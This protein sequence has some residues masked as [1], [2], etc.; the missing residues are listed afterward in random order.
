[1]EQRTDRLAGR[2]RQLMDNY[3][4]LEYFG[5][6][7]SPVMRLREL[8]KSFCEADHAFSGRFLS[9]LNRIVR[10]SEL[11]GM[12]ELGSFEVREFGE[13][14]RTRESVEKFLNNGTQEEIEG[15]TKVYMKEMPEDNF[16]S[17]L[18]RQ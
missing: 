18:M 5:G 7:G 12:Q 17:L 6:I 1:M 11:E 9:R 16:K 14:E 3:G 10:V 4:D 13:F 2:I 8:P 15:F